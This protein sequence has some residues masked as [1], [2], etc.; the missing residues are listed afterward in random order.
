MTALQPMHNEKGAGK[1]E[2]EEMN[3]WINILDLEAVEVGNTIS[4]KYTQPKL[5]CFSSLIFSHP[6]HHK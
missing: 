2:A 6:F 1:D 4:D 5:P 3:K